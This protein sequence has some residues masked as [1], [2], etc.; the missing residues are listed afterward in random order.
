[1]DDASRA[2]SRQRLADCARHDRRIRVLNFTPACG[3]SAA[4]SAGLALAS[5]DIIVTLPAGDGSVGAIIQLLLEE[6]VRVDLVVGRPHR[7]GVHKLFHRLA[8][9]PRWLLLGLEV[10]DPECLVWAA[11]REAVA[12]VELPCG[13][14]RYLATLV[15]ARGYRVGEITV[16]TPGR[17]VMLS[18]GW[19]NPGDL[20]AAWWFKRRWR[21]YEH[22]ELI[23]SR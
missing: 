6:L 23:Q 2:E 11:R 19:P 18:D 16:P 3:L 17:S 1:M 7:Q 10:R 15:A 20:L 13:M 8:R 9:I 14:Y 4:L 22:V 21:Q 12:G 5:G